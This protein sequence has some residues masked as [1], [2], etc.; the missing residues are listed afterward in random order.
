MKIGYTVY[1]RQGEHDKPD[2]LVGINIPTTF[3]TRTEVLDMADQLCRIAAEMCPVKEH[4][5]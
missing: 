4:I 2:G 3:L 1:A 5:G